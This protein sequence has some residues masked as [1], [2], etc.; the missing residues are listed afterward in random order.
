MPRI[1]KEVEFLKCNLCGHEW[2][3][4]ENTDKRPDGLPFVCARCK[5]PKWDEVKKEE[6]K[7]GK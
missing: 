6:K 2:E 4:R 5:S 3:P 7:D 1:I